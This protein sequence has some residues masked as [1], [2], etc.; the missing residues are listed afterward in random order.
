MHL[1]QNRETHRPDPP[2]QAGAPA[3]LASALIR[4]S[5]IELTTNGRETIAAAAEILP[6][7]TAVYVPKLPRQSLADKLVQIRTLREFGLEPIPHIAARQLSSAAE[8]DCFLDRAHGEAGVRRVLII[9]GDKPEPI[10]PFPDS[11]AVLATA[12]LPRHGIDTVDV[13]G[14][15]ESHPRIPGEILVADLQNKHALAAARGLDLNIVTQFCFDADAILDFCRKLLN[16]APQTAVFAGMAGPTSPARLLR[17]AQICGVGTSL[18]AINSLGKNAVRLAMNASPDRQISRL[19]AGGHD[20]TPANL[21]GIHL[22]SFGGFTESARW[23][24][25]RRLAA[26][27]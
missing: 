16:L 1:F 25:N 18:R 26:N 17:Y 7:G 23:L 2:R 3:E 19:C 6:S 22:F 5:S 21:R 4:N 15:P 10:G 12:D 11:A 27:P 8:L 9:G 24:G 13:A 20:A 14:Y